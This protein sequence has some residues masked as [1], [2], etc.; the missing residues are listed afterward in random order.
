[1]STLR[2]VSNLTETRTE[3]LPKRLFIKL[4][5]TTY[6]QDKD[7]ACRPVDVKLAV[8]RV[9]S[10]DALTREKVHDVLWSVLVAICCCHLKSQPHSNRILASASQA[11][12]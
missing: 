10:V 1:M 9:I 2:T 7:L 3:Y 8:G 6:L 11:H 12:S 5:D 4:T